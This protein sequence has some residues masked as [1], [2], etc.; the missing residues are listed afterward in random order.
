M[1]KPTIVAVDPGVNGGIAVFIPSEHAGN[2][3]AI[4]SVCCELSMQPLV[5]PA[6]AGDQHLHADVIESV[7]EHAVE[8]MRRQPFGRPRRS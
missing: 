5:G 4:K 8:N 3:E 2:V 1:N 6:V 7:A